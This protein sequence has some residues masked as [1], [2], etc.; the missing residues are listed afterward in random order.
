MQYLLLVALFLT[1]DLQD[2][3]VPDSRITI[4]VPVCTKT[5]HSGNIV[6]KAENNVR[7]FIMR[8]VNCY[9]T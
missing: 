4:V 1:E 6:F 2:G 7:R 5:A 8:T 9:T 3:P